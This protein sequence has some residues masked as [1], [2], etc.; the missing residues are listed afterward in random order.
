MPGLSGLDVLWRLR[1]DERTRRIPVVMLTSSHRASDIAECYDRGANGYVR[2]PVDFARFVE[3]A[4]QLQSYWRVLNESP[5]H[6][7][8]P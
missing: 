6:P 2:K 8:A 5:H 7:T 4:R 3:T 1:T